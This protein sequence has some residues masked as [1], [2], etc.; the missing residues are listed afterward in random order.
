MIAATMEHAGWL[1]YDAGWNERAR[2]WWLETRH[3]AEINEV[4]DVGVTA[5]TSMARQATDRGD[6]R[7]A[8]DLIHAA[9]KTIANDQASPLLLSLLAAREAVGY[10]HAGERKA[11]FAALDQARQ[12]LDCGRRGDEP[13]WLDFWVTADLAWHETQV[14]WAAGQGRSAEIAARTALARVDAASFQRNHTLY[15]TNLGSILTQ[16]GQLDE[17]ISI[18]SMAVQG[19]PAI[20]GSGRLCSNLR[21]AVD[22]LD[23]QKYPPAK[24]F[25]NAAR[26][27]LPAVS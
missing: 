1:A 22:F 12:W 27:L 13:F 21:R 6:G 20:L 25:A 2:R 8:V 5:L 26:R 19:A 15:A 10:A 18:T 16:R 14:A 3:F 7:E 9:K 17:A 24:V 23:Q 4:P 11:A